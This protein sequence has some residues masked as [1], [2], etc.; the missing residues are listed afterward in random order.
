MS[1]RFIKQALLFA[2]VYYFAMVTLGGMI[3]LLSHI[4]PAPMN[5]DAIILKV[6]A[7]REILGYPRPWLRRLWP[8]ET[9][10]AAVNFL[11]A[12]MTCL[13]WGFALSGVKTLWSRAK[14]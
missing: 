2:V 3:F 14:K 8:G 12:W 4:P 7:L 10:P 13:I 11:C 1:P 9:T 6:T 5:L